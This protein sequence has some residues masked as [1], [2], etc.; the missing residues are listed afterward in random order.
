MSALRDVNRQDVNRR[1]INLRRH[2]ERSRF[3]GE[4]RDLPRLAAGALP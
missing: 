1:A 4:E 2:P 3:S